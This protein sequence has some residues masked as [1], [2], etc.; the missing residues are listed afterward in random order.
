MKRVLVIDDESIVRVSCQRILIPEGYEVQLASS[1]MEGLAYLQREPFDL[2]LLDLK[3]P[4]MDGVEVL[5]EIK[6]KWPDIPIII[7]TGYNTIQAAE[8]MIGLGASSF[9]EKPFKPDTL[10]SAVKKLL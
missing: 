7:I 1:G 4:D 8:Q 6:E 9:I 3:M 5:Q 10:L 2:V